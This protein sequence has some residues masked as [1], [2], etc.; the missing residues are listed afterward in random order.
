MKHNFNFNRPLRKL[1]HGATRQ[2][3]EGVEFSKRSSKQKKRWRFFDASK[4][5]LFKTHRGSYG[6]GGAVIDQIVRVNH[7]GEYAAVYMYLGQLDEIKRKINAKPLTSFVGEEVVRHIAHMLSVEKKHLA[8]FQSELR[9]RCMNPTIFLPLWR[10]LSYYILG[11]LSLGISIRQGMLTTRAVEEVIEKHY[12]GQ[13]NVLRNLDL[14]NKP[15]AKFGHD[16]QIQEVNKGAEPRAYMKLSED[17]R[18]GTTMQLAS[19]VEFEGGLNEVEDLLNHIVEF[20]NEEVDHKK[21]ADSYVI[22]DNTKVKPKVQQIRCKNESEF[23]FSTK[24][25]E[26]QKS[27]IQSEKLFLYKEAIRYLKKFTHRQP[28]PGVAQYKMIDFTYAMMVKAACRL[29]IVISKLI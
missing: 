2:C 22:S 17:S 27:P 3:H 13:V 15:L 14:K 1:T 5:L 6:F 25:K 29:A 18:I 10:L 12:Q 24:E 23:S 26:G 19:R 16:E 9:R 21:L 28:A 20:Y 11:R 8:F 7:A 4:Y